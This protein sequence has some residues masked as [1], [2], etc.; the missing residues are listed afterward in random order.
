MIC[1]KSSN[2]EFG[3][4]VTYGIRSKYMADDD[5]RYMNI[6]DVAPKPQLIMQIIKKLFDESVMPE[7]TF[8]AV[9]D[10]LR[11]SLKTS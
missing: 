3:E 7:N 2:S 8:D 4:F 1:K 9:E 6:D 5:F 11:S 10:F